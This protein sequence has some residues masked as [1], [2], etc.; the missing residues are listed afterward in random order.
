MQIPEDLL[1]GAR[2]A[3]KLAAARPITF[4]AGCPH[5]GTYMAI[6][7]AIRKA[8][9]KKKDVMVTGDIGCTILGMNPPFNTCS[10]EV[11]MGASIGIAQGFAQAGVKTP[12][13]ATMGDS[14]FFHAGIPS[15][16]SAI[17][18][19]TPITVV[20]LDNGWTS[21]T[22]MQVNPG[23]AMDY[24]QPGNIKLDLAKVI[25]ALGVEQFWM[26]DPFQLEEATK[27]LQNA[28]KLPG[29]K[30]VL[31]RQECAMPAK[32]RGAMSGKTTV[33]AENCTLCKLCVIQTGCPAISLGEDSII[34]DDDLCYGCGL[35]ATTCNKDAIL[36]ERVTA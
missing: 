9:F 17:Q 24:Q 5:R 14:T 29:V 3:Q 15:L 35:C 1:H 32:R 13:I 7:A 21:M 8:G 23:T 2:E 31:A 11:S 28:I 10:T 19:Q 36:V 12:V 22:G 26:I 27:V 18:H 20:V 16:L 30:V 25:P 33:V 4:C 6:N 34:I